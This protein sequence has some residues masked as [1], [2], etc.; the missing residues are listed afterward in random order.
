MVQATKIESVLRRARLAGLACAIGAALAC[1]P[2]QGFTARAGQASAKPIGTTAGPRLFKR[3]CSDCH[4][5]A[6]G[7]GSMALARKY[8]GN[9]P[10]LL[11][12]RTDTSADFIKYV[13]RHGASFM[14]PFRKTEITDAELDQLALYLTQSADDR[15][16]S[17][18]GRK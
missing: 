10:A 13:V 4:H 8:Q 9:L 1:L 11:E 5:L 14:P 16:K 6:A 12:Q 7:P 15:R 17:S 2:V 3:W 18:R